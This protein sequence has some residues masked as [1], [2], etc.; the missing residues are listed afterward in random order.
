MGIEQF[1]IAGHSF[2]GYMAVAYAL[3]HPTRVSSVVLV[4]PAGLSG[5]PHETR[6]TDY[7]WRSL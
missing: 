2:G 3:K 1:D 4:S 7:S 6:Q 5:P